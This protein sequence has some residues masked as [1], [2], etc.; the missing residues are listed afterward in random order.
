M[1][2]KSPLF[3]AVVSGLIAVAATVGAFTASRVGKYSQARHDVQVIALVL[4]GFVQENHEYPQGTR[5]EICRLLRGESINGQNLKKLDYIEAQP[6]EV[7]ANGEFMDPWGEA[8]RI[9]V[10]PKIRV[11]SCG[12]NRIDEQGEGDDIASWK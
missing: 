6:Y 9:A 2:K 12:P 10:D 1:K 5:G 11:Y 7:N 4:D 8:Y 3:W